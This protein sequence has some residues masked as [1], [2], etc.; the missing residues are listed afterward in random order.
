[1]LAITDR[2][3]AYELHMNLIA[4][5][6]GSADRGRAAGIAPCRGCA[7]PGGPAWSTRSPI[8]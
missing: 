1:M 8:L 7:S 5:A 2:A 4:T 3:D 6:A